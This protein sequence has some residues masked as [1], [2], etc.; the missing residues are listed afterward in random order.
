M[1]YLIVGDPH[2]TPDSLEECGH[3]IDLVINTAIQSSVDRVV[4]LG[5]LYHN[6]GIVHLSV[7][8]FWQE[9]FD[10]MAR[11]GLDVIALV[12]NHDRPGNEAATENALMLHDHVAVIDV[13]RTIDGMLFLPFT[14]DREQFVKWCNASEA[15]IVFAHQE[16]WGGKYDNG[17]P[18]TGE[19]TGGF[20][21]P[22]A[23]NPNLIKQKII[24]GHI[25]T[26]QRFGEV[27]YPGAP[28][29]RTIH[30]ANIFRSIYVVEFGGDALYRVV[31]EVPTNTVCRP[32]HVVV[33]QEGDAIPP[34]QE[35]AN[36]TFDVHGTQAYVDRRKVEL[37]AKG[38]KVRSFATTERQIKVKES[39]GLVVAFQKYVQVFKAKN[40]TT[41]EV[42]MQLAM[43]RVS[44]L[45]PISK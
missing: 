25:H 23:V 34:L 39:D 14:S 44:W 27:W 30:D 20:Y 31:K 3:L 10:R 13:P 37:E 17:T 24:S 12:G 8:R 9:Q 38:Y 32:I 18:I 7:Q 5:D 2:A 43:E 16:F 41:P 19:A 6:H 29:W 40:G 1:Q 15:P 4:F 26:P 35:G 11:S 45:R 22:L 42:L 36:V 21:S 28:R 33:D